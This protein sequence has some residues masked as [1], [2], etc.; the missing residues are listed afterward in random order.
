MAQ[1]RLYVFG[2]PRLE[3]DGEAVD[4]SLRRA[5]ALLVYL[6]VTRQPQGRDALATLLWP[7]SDQREARANLRRTLHRLGQVVGDDVLATNAE[8][9]SIAPGAALTLDSEQ[10]VQLTN[11]GERLEDAVDLYGDDFLAGFTLPDSPA[12]DEWQFFERERLRQL[13]AQSLEWLTQQ[14]HS[15]GVWNAAADYARRWVALDVLHEPAQ[16]SLL[17]AYAQLGQVAAAQRQYQEL[18]RVL[19]MEL[20]A[21]PEEA[22]RALYEAIRTRRFPASPA[23]HGLPNAGTTRAQ[24]GP[25]PVEL[26]AEPPLVGRERELEA[27]PRLLSKAGGARLVTLTGPGGVGK[28]RLAQAIAETASP[29]FADGAHVVMLAEVSKP[30]GIVPAIAA[31]LGLRAGDGDS[32]AQLLAVLRGRELLLVLD[33]LEHLLDGVTTVAAILG[34]TTRTHIIITSRERLDL[35]DEVVYPLGGLELPAEESGTQVLDAPAARLLLQRARL[36]RPELA[37]GP[38]DVAGITRICRLVQGLPLALTLAAGWAELLSF[39]EIADEIACSL[40]FLATDQRDVPERQRSMRAVFERSWHRLPVDEQRVFARLTVFRGGFTRHAA[41]DVAGASLHQL[42]R[43]VNTSWITVSAQAHRYEIHELLGQFVAETTAGDRDVEVA[44]HRHAALY[45]DLVR[46]LTEDLKG[47]EQRQAVITLAGDA[48]N[49]RA[50]WRYAVTHG[51]WEAIAG[52][53]EGLWLFYE[54]AG[55]SATGEAAFAEALAALEAAGS[56][57]D[58]GL[59]GFLLAAQGHFHAHSSTF[60]AGRALMERGVAQMRATPSQLPLALALVFLGLLARSQGD[61]AAAQRLGEESL[62]LFAEADDHWGVALSLQL[63][64]TALARQGRPVLAQQLL[65]A[66]V[67]TA[68][69]AGTH[70]TWAFAAWML[71]Q[72]LAGFG[73]YA[74]AQRLLDEA[75]TVGQEAG[76]RLSVATALAERAF[77]ALDLGDLDGA[78]QYFAESISLYEAIGNTIFA[79]ATRTHTGILARL[80]GEGAKAEAVLLKGLART[81]ALQYRRDQALLLG[82]LALLAVDRGDRQHAAQ[83]QAEALA[84]W[85]A[86][87]NEPWIAAASGQ[88]AATRVSLGSPAEE[89]EALIRTALSLALRHRLAPTA[90]MIFVGLASYLA[91]QGERATP[92]ELLALAEVHPAATFET[93]R[94]ATARAAELSAEIPPAEVAAAR[95]RGASLDWRAVAER[96][97]AGPAVAGTRHQPALTNLD[98]RLPPLF[99]RN[100]EL[101]QLAGLLSG[102]ARRLI[103]LLGPGGIGKTRLAQEAGLAMLDSYADGIFFVDLASVA[104]PAQLP[105]AIAAP[106]GLRLSGAGEPRDQLLRLLDRKQLL[107]VLDNF[108]HLLEG[109]DL[110]PAILQAAPKVALLVTTRERLGLDGE[111]VYTLGGI[112]IPTGEDDQRAIERGAVQLLLQRV[113]QVRPAFDPGPRDLDALIRI[114][115]LVQGM[116]LAIILAASWADLLGLDAIAAEIERGL[117]VLEADLRALPPRQRSVRAVFEG[118]WRHL[119]A[120]AQVCFARMAVFRGGFSRH[121]A[122]QVAGADLHV[123]RSLVN[124]SFISP[125]GDSRY[126]LHEL[127]RQFGAERLAALGEVEQLRDRHSV[128]YLELLRGLEPDLRR[129][130]Q[131]EAFRIIEDDLDNIRQA[132]EHAVERQARERL[133]QAVDAVYLFA[134]KRGRFR[135]GADLLQETRDRLAATPAADGEL[136]L[137]LTTRLSLLR[138]LFPP[139]QQVPVSEVEHCRILAHQRGQA[140]EEA[141]A[142]LAIGMYYTRT[143]ND[144]QQAL[145][146]FEPSLQLLRALDDRYY[147]AEVLARYGICRGYTGDVPAFYRYC[148]EGCEIAR[149]D[150]NDL[151]LVTARGNLIESLLHLGRYAEVVEHC[152][153]QITLSEQFGA[154][155]SVAHALQFLALT[156]FLEGDLAA[157]RQAATQGYVLSAEIQSALAM[158]NSLSLQSL[159]ASVSG[160]FPLGRRFAEE[161]QAHPLNLLGLV[162]AHLGDAIA[163]RGLGAHTDARRSLAE[164]L[165]FAR[166]FATVVPM[167]WV[168]PVAALLLGDESRHADATALLALAHTHELSPSGWLTS[169]RALSVLRA[170]L[171]QALEPEAFATAWGRGTQFD[172]PA[173][174]ALLDLHLERRPSITAKD[175]KE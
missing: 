70:S 145:A 56:R 128:Y 135:E 136:W 101:G 25:V 49:L 9:I 38:A 74:G 84:L 32:T 83:L 2:P 129:R 111:L 87:E 7:E 89:T 29:H 43:L 132:W 127:L 108:E 123:L 94:R 90:L 11:A 4:L 69:A 5:L 149:S 159:V 86:L 34:A 91:A 12:F 28:T 155:N 164:A 140:F 62:A 13:L 175:A 37:P 154:R 48:D 30:A 126:R 170:S 71:A 51:E 98:I 53:A 109:V 148:R 50:A 92:L 138:S 15:R 44:H 124:S 147:L 150:E 17:E 59:A 141:L 171:E 40:D 52:A 118:S 88:L 133:N 103:T 75:I 47:P 57:A 78:E 42:R 100:Y 113:R 20:G 36:V 16:R 66:C 160:D 19:E 67:E 21:E 105:A 99:G 77:L 144:Y 95:Q 82:E 31:R 146:R 26:P 33:N 73:E 18:A 165:Q 23:A 172:I 139:E 8:T 166:R 61:L 151:G 60:A 162:Q 157:S 156:R 134:D 102:A 97:A 117:D 14:A 120:T 106:L 107:L 46:S 3:R 27:I 85:H 64:G 161:A 68:R 35:A 65:H 152:Q 1:L 39:E 115:R 24:E 114:A 54:L 153:R 167:L 41:Q 22:T 80:R 122:E 169:W 143:A 63:L 119:P 45:L 93:R 121:A 174:V 104:D 168:L 173:A 142:Y 6:A 125:D 163:R 131:A 79:E 110:I 58:D 112:E 55:H 76:Y 72:V 96:F 130:R 10:F 137:R 116:P 158:G 81:R